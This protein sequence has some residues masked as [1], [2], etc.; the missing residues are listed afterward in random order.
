MKR[1]DEAW[2]HEE[3]VRVFLENIR[4]AIPFLE[5]QLDTMMR[6][7]EGL[8]VRS[9]LDLGCGDGILSQQIL[10]K[11]PLARGTLLDFSGAMLEKAREGLKGKSRRLDFV[12][13]DFSNINWP[14]SA[15]GP[16]KKTFDV[17]V[18]GYAIHHQCEDVK[19]AI[20]KA[21]FDLLKPGGL[22]VNIDHIA[23]PTERTREISNDFFIERLKAFHEAKGGAGDFEKVRDIFRR[24]MAEEAGV[25]S[26][27]GAQFQWLSECGFIEVDCF[28]KSFELAVF[29]GRKP[30][31]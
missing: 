3:Q 12:E 28:F 1:V 8:P 21:I 5:A 29:S 30:L 23:S 6:L 7:M 17:V 25:L 27:L 16:G 31:T 10:S 26:T 19:K 2:K 9:F 14:E 22:F 15:L 20:F 24:R 4:G 13:A 11:Y 18:S